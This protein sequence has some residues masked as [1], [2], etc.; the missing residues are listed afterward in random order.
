M[1]IKAKAYCAKVNDKLTRLIQDTIKKW[2]AA[3]L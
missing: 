3:G 2:N 1:N